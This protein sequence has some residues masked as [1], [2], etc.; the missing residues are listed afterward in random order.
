M[1]NDEL[2][3]NIKTHKK[4]KGQ[5]LLYRD[6]QASKINEKYNL[7]TQFEYVLNAIGIRL[8]DFQEKAILAYQDD[9]DIFIAGGYG[10]GRSTTID[11]LSVYTLFFQGQ[12]IIY[13]L[14]NTTQLEEKSERLRSSI[15]K[16]I[17]TIPFTI[18]FSDSSEHLIEKLKHY[19]EIVI[20]TAE[21]FYNCIKKYSSDKVLRD[22]LFS[23][24][25]VGIE[26]IELYKPK[27]IIFI[28]RLINLLD[29]F[30]N[31]RFAITSSSDEDFPSFSN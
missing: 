9:K 20:T 31:T 27:E 26:K 29:F 23:L 5:L 2:I 8:F 11:I 25:L 21:I 24:G 16:I 6:I 3:R 18:T 22:F 10:S 12:S 14:P 15:Q 1:S 30:S 13:L 7:N 4:Y 19:P 17:E 28:T